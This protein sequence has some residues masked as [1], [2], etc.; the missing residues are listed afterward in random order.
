M[1]S[2]MHGK[3]TLIDLIDDITAAKPIADRNSKKKVSRY[4][5]NIFFTDFVLKSE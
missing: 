4:T 1:S 5:D 2:K 3:Y